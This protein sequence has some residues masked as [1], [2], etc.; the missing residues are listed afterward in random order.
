MY[1]RLQVLKETTNPNVTP[2]ELFHALQSEVTSSRHLLT[3]QLPLD[4][5]SASQALEQ[6]NAQLRIPAKTEGDIRHCQHEIA[7]LTGESQDLIS[8]IQILEQR[9]DKLA[10]FR[11]H[12]SVQ[13]KKLWAIRDTREEWLTK[14]G[15]LRQEREVVEEVLSQVV[16]PKYMKREEFKTYANALRVKT[17]AYK[18]AKV[19]FVVGFVY[20]DMFTIMN[21][22]MHEYVNIYIYI[23]DTT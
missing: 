22:P 1:Q 10:I 21:M 9:D 19:C 7:R 20:R 13:M 16:G 4:L 15:V 12:A 3:T 5:Q 2:E 23:Y 11:Q 6:V 17:S 18:L 8:Q 14:V